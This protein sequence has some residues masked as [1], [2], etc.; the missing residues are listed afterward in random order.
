MDREDGGVMDREIA[1]LMSALSNEEAVAKLKSLLGASKDNCKEEIE[2]LKQQLAEKEKELQKM[3]K[4]TAEIIRQIPKP[5]FVLFMNR[6]GVIEYI[7][8]YAAEVYGG[9]IS[10]LIGKRP[11]E[12]AKNLAAG[13]KTLVEIAFE[14]RAKMKVKRDF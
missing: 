2:K 5:A 4:F 9:S 6:D 11:S 14:N 8:D 13:D 3:K 12:L 10:D 7:N 1:D